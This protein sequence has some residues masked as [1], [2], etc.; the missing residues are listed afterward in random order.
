[1][2]FIKFRKFLYFW[3]SKSFIMNW[4]WSTSMLLCINWYNYYIISLLKWWVTLADFW[5]LTLTWLTG[6]NLIWF[7][8]ISIILFML[9]WNQFTNILLRT[10]VSVFEILICVRVVLASQN[11]LGSIPFS[12]FL[13]EVE[14]IGITF[15]WGVW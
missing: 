5:M 6:I 14:V 15:P 9:Y 10:V 7:W 2:F 13:K 4:Y 1:M 3:F 8:Y 11:Q 12:C